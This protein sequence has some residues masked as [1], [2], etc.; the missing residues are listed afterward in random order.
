MAG[1]DWAVSVWRRMISDVELLV[2]GLRD[3]PDSGVVSSGPDDPDDPDDP[4]ESGPFVSVPLTLPILDTGF[5]R[6]SRPLQDSQ[7]STLGC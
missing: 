4:D 3:G 1:E 7:A 6:D 5:G 2:L